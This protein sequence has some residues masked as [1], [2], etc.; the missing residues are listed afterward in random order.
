[1]SEMSDNISRVLLPRIGIPLSFFLSFFLSFHCVRF[2]PPGLFLSIFRLLSGLKTLLNGNIGRFLAAIYYHNWVITRPMGD[3]RFINQK[4]EYKSPSDLI[5]NN[6]VRG[7]CL[8]CH[9]FDWYIDKYWQFQFDNQPPFHHL[10]LN[11]SG[12]EAEAGNIQKRGQVRRQT[13]RRKLIL[14]EREVLPCF[15]GLINP[16]WRIPENPG[17]SLTELQGRA[18]GIRVNFGDL[19]QLNGMKPM[20]L[21]CQRHASWLA[22]L[23]K[24][25]I[26]SN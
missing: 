21:K 12:S 14:A 22:N 20:E 19:M 3:L 9:P 2:F 23:D 4:I 10:K 17:K 13:D 8:P 5:I 24:F 25:K 1:M 26:W 11:C 16:S 7:R 6:K 18:S 15:Q